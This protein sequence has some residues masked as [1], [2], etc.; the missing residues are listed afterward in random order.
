VKIDRQ[1]VS[2]GKVGDVKLAPHFGPPKTPSSN[3]VLPLPSIVGDELAAH[4]AAFSEG[5]DRLVFTASTGAM[6]S[7]QTWHAAFSATAARLKIDASSHDLRHHAV[8]LLISSGCSPKAVASFLGHKNASETL[9]TYAIC[10]RPMRIGSLRRST[11]DW[12]R[13]VDPPSRRCKRDN[14][15]SFAPIERPIQRACNPKEF[16]NGAVNLVL[17]HRVDRR[18]DRAFVAFRWL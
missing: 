14:L 12:R 9:N 6:I 7:R 1:V 2:P 5:L 17:G 8:S 15:W 11:A 16:S 10:G 18:V 3:R 4:L 13:R